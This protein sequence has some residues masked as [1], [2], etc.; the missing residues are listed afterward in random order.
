MW[1]TIHLSRY[2]PDE[3]KHIIDP[4]LQRNGFFGHPENILLA[5]ITDERKHVRELGLRR[6]LKARSTRV[7][8]IR[9]FTVP[10]LNYDSSD[11]LELIDW[12]NTNLTEPPLITDLSD[13][14]IKDLVTNG[15]ST[16]VDFPRFPSHTQAVER[17]V[18]LVT[19]ASA[20]VCGQTSRDGFI[21]SRLEGRR[22]M[23][24]FNTKAQYH[25]AQ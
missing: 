19:Q 11:Y 25:V 16:I 22:I 5:M 4:V 20:A 12:Q 8:G 3:L 14:V 7:A 21:R 9:K 23:P 15:E 13:A 24:T 10:A 1:R 2:L 6:I 17:C 18:K